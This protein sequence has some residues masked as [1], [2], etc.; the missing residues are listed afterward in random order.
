MGILYLVLLRLESCG[1]SYSI[2][3]GLGLEISRTKETFELSS[4]LN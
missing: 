2:F 1:V 3:S 4:T